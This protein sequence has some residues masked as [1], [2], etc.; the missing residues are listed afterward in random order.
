MTPLA[1]AKHFETMRRDA[2]RDLVKALRVARHDQ[3][4]HWHRWRLRIDGGERG[5]GGR[6]HQDR[7]C[8]L[9][10]R[11]D[12]CRHDYLVAFSC[13]GRGVCPSCNTRRMAEAAAHLTDHA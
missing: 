9:A 12:D 4:L 6:A 13:K 5:V 1:A 10:S 7:R 8:A 3:P 11:C 2:L